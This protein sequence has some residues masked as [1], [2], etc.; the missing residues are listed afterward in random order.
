M[1]AALPTM[2]ALL[3]LSA[4][5]GF[6]EPC[7]ATGDVAGLSWARFCMF[8]LSSEVILLP[9]RAF[10]GVFAPVESKTL[11]APVPHANRY[12]SAPSLHE[13]MQSKQSTHLL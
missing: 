6:C 11:A 7:R 9:A 8:L 3:P 4:V 1:T 12:L 2:K 10:C 5:S 13:S